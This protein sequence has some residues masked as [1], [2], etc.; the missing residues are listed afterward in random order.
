MQYL[1]QSFNLLN[2]YTDDI[3][4]VSLHQRWMNIKT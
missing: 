4:A 1:F 3:I 2:L